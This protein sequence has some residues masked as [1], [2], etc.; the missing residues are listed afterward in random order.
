MNVKR[1]ILIIIFS[2]F[3]LVLMAGKARSVTV[4]SVDSSPNPFGPIPA[5]NSITITLTGIDDY[6]NIIYNSSGNIVRRLQNRTSP[7]SPFTDDWDG[8]SDSGSGFQSGTFDIYVKSTR[9]VT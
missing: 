2:V 3:I 5:T 1:N 6:V 7:A 9:I 8:T 4:T